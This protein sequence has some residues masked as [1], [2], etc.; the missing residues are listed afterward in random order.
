MSEAP[1]ST[2]SV[3]FFH[4]MPVDE[5]ASSCGPLAFHPPNGHSRPPY[6]DCGCNPFTLSHPH[7]CLQVN[8]NSPSSG[9]HFLQARFLVVL[10]GRLSVAG[11]GGAK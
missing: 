6:F 2:V 5:F 8:P 1:L 3:I 11:V 7:S 10:I 9:V 4:D